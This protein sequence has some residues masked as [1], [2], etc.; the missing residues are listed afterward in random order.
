MEVLK[1]IIFLL[2][3]CYLLW[4]AF[5]LAAPPKKKPPVKRRFDCPYIIYDEEKKVLPNCG[6]TDGSITGLA[7]HTDGTKINYTWHNAAGVV[8]GRNRD[9]VDVGEGAYRLEISDNSGCNN[10]VFSK[11][12]VLSPNNGIVIN[13]DDVNTHFS[14]CS[15][16]GYIKGLSVSNATSYSWKN[17]NTGQT[18]KSTTTPD[19]LNVPPGDYKLTAANSNGCSTE[20]RAFTVNPD[21]DLPS[22]AGYSVTD[23]LCGAEAGS[24]IVDLFLRPGGPRL[25]YFFALASDP[26]QDHV[27]DGIIDTYLPTAKATLSVTPDTYNFYVYL[28]Y[29]CPVLL[30]SYTIGLKRI[31]INIEASIVKNDQCGQHLGGIVPDITGGPPPSKG[32][33]PKYKWVDVSTG[34]VISEIKSLFRVGAGQYAFT[35]AYQ[36]GCRDTKIFT[37]TNVAEPPPP[38]FVD[39]ATLCL[40]GVAALIVKDKTDTADTYKLYAS[41]QDSVALDS[42]KFGEFYRKINQTTDFYVSRK[43]FDCESGRVK[44]TEVVIANIALTN[45]FTPNNDGINDTWTIAGINEFRDAEVNIFDRNGHNIYRSVG[46]GIPFDGRYRGRLIPAGVYYYVINLKQPACYGKIA[47]S[48][49]ILH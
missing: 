34:K 2:F 25:S 45:T 16:D 41:E 43:R 44:V 7:V 9:L 12:Y 20:S 8:V 14:T 11:N 17:S 36:P 5:I 39:G 29:K 4:P 47:G 1:R 37:I 10:S 48:L 38:P 24:L 23:A 15:S 31:S 30:G 49:T 13:D 18:Y 19:L 28:D 26:M 22:I 3:T 40:P 42:N 32:S 33:M 21:F 35:V 6:K 46:Y 27:K